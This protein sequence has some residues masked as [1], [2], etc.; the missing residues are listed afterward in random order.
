MAYGPPGIMGGHIYIDGINTGSLNLDFG[1][2][3]DFGDHELMTTT[4]RGVGPRGVG[5][6][7]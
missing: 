6:A 7:I 4:T 5:L 3:S 1:G 2:N